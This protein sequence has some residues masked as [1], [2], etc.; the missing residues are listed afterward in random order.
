MTPLNKNVRGSGCTA[1]EH[2][3]NVKPVSYFSLQGWDTASSSF[4]FQQPS[5]PFH[6]PPISRQRSARPHNA[7]TG[8]HQ[9][10]AIH[11]AGPRHCSRSFRLTH[12]AGEFTVTPR[13]TARDLSQRLP[14][15]E[16]KHSSAQIQRTVQPTIS[17]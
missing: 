14:H 9:G 6:T 2:V 8:N 4:R 1:T 10:H 16:L 3:E 5:L 12:R 15:A 7:M 13:F 11:C 17:R